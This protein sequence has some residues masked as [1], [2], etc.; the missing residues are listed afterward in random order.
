VEE[1]SREGLVDDDD[2][3]E[4]EQAAQ[5]TLWHADWLVAF[6]PMSTTFR[7]GN[8]FSAALA[9]NR[10]RRRAWKAA[11][12]HRGGRALRSAVLGPAHERRNSTRVGHRKTPRD[13]PRVDAR[14]ASRLVALRGR[15]RL[16]WDRETGT[17]L[18]ARDQIGI[19]PI[20]YARCGARGWVLSPSPD[21]LT[22][23]PAVS[24][25]PDAVAISEWLCGWF[26]AVE[27]TA[28][29][30]V[31]RVPPGSV[32]TFPEAN[33]RRY[34]DT[35]EEGRPTE[36]LRE[37]DLEQFEPL[38]RRAVGRATQ[39]EAPAIFLSGG[40]DSISVAV[41]ASDLAARNDRPLALSLV[42]PDE[43]SSE[44]AIQKGVARQL[45]IDQV[46]LPFAEAAGPRGLLAEAL[47]I[48]ATWPQPMWNIWSP[49]YV[50]RRSRSTQSP[51]DPDRARRGRVADDFALFVGRPDEAGDV[52]GM[53]VSCRCGGA[54]TIWLGFE[55]RRACLA[56][57]VPPA[58][59]C[60]V[61]C[62]GP[63]TVA[64]AASPSPADGEA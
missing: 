5:P 41:T 21:V 6:G 1:F 60:R 25:D 22:S 14:A 17:L 38:L 10:G 27:D 20:F 11:I 30:D 51:G 9:A 2:P 56:D 12:S 40:I 64:P 31:K 48:S 34:W 36:W 63:E 44:E 18:V 43:A 26:P 50:W 29:R 52:A 15:S 33:V 58:G 47:E 35:F 4:P 37:K 3:S 49:R 57:R 45:G 55:R 24:R 19:E 7:T 28:Y 32:V 8:R 53:C 54:R 61:R 16:S 42:F 13:R 62:G 39:G 23:H 59:Q 46:L